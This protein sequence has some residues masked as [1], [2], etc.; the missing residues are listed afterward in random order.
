MAKKT[1]RVSSKK[2][3]ASNATLTWRQ[4]LAINARMPFALPDEFDDVVDGNA[5]GVAAEVIQTL[6]RSRD[7]SFSLTEN[8]LFGVLQHAMRAGFV[9]G[10]TT[11]I[12]RYREW[13]AGNPELDR[14]VERHSRQGVGTARSRLSQHKRSLERARKA[15]AMRRDGKSDDEIARYMREHEGMKKCRNETINRWIKVLSEQ[16]Q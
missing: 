7:R 2:K 9:L 12:K 13:L 1:T 8:E 16:R 6:R 14:L 10:F 11:A 4:Q 15:E 5:S 3:A